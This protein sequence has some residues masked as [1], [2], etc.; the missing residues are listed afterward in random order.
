[1]EVSFHLGSAVP[2]S[3]PCFSK[4]ETKARRGFKKI[5]LHV[6][7][8]GGHKFGKHQLFHSPNISFLIF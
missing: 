8:L 2:C 6:L 1:M 7:G 5:L 4:E 3:V